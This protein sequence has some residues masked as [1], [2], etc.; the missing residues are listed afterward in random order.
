MLK[1]E[2]V[3]LLYES[4][5]DSP[6]LEVRQMLTD[7]GGVP[8]WQTVGADLEITDP[9]VL[10][11][12][13]RRAEREP[14]QYIIGRVDFCHESYKVTPDCLIPRADTELLVEYAAKNLP[15]GALFLDLCTGSGCVAIS[16]LAATVGTRAI[17]TDI[18]PDTLRLARENAEYNKVGDRVEF[19]ECDALKKGSL[20]LPTGARVHA[21]LSN[22]PYVRRAVYETLEPE[23]FREPRRAF[24]GGEDGLIF[25]RAI[26]EEFSFV[27]KD[28]GFLAYE[29]GYDQSD[30]IREI[31]EENGLFAE[32]LTDLS[33][34]PRVAVL[35]AE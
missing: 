34:N 8:T 27:A 12:I 16:T 29:I 14:L 31:A 17:A 24:V 11:A 35:K 21:V 10:E 6:E 1:S 9:R 18:S 22:P 7:I 5:I 26:T 32:I 4:G 25:Y 3:R 19:F 30:A 13:R 15:E 33:G 23:I 20:S 28:G 2:A